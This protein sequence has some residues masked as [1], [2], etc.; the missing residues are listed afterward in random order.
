MKFFERTKW[1]LTSPI[2]LGLSALI[3]ISYLIYFI[4]DQIDYRTELVSIPIPPSIQL[5]NA[6]AN[7]KVDPKPE[8][9]VF[10][11][12]E[13]GIN[14]TPENIRRFSEDRSVDISVLI[15]DNNKRIFGA[16]TNIESIKKED[17]HL[18]PYVNFGFVAEQDET[19]KI[20][21]MSNKASWLFE[22]YKPVI[23]IYS[24][25]TID[26]TG[27]FLAGTSIIIWSIL[28]VGYLL[29]MIFFSHK[30]ELFRLQQ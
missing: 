28:L 21:V 9:S 16:S 18:E 14:A 2:C 22:S 29:F 20:E 30:S 10:V 1:A 11:V 3:G 23:K 8:E 17:Q 12:L 7:I 4:A 27:T 15:T 19:I 5:F 24:S 13:F 26:V 25:P 6:Q